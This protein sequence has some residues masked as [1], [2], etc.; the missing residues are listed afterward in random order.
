M[1]KLDG[2]TAK[3]EVGFLLSNFSSVLTATSLKTQYITYLTE[4]YIQ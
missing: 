1:I 4:T 2:E 3:Q